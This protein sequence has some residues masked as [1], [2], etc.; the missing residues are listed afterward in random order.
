MKIFVYILVVISM[1]A[2]L[3]GADTKQRKLYCKYGRI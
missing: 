1:N 3:V 2:A